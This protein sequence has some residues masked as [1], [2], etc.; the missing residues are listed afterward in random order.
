MVRPG[1]SSSFRCLCRRP[2]PALSGNHP[3]FDRDGTGSRS[4]Y[5]WRVADVR[6][7]D[8]RRPF[9]Q[10]LRRRLRRIPK[11]LGR[12][13]ASLSGKTARQQDRDGVARSDH[14]SRGRPMDTYIARSF[15]QYRRRE[16]S[17]A[18]TQPLRSGDNAVLSVDGDVRTRRTGR[19]D[20]GSI[21]DRL[22]PDYRSDTCGT[23]H[24]RTADQAENCG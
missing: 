18:G 3:R 4:R 22:R 11:L 19:T 5:P 14:R 23:R 10:M 21:R 13:R 17:L 6:R 2:L 16:D 8:L 24:I 1:G 15:L 9:F 12:S 7:K 20:P